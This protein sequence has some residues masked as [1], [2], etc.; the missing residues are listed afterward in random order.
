MDLTG[1][2]GFY[3]YSSTAA[4]FF[5]LTLLLL[6]SRLGSKTSQTQR[7]PPSFFWVALL[8]TAL[9]A[10]ATASGYSA[11][12]YIPLAVF[13][14][15][16]FKSLSWL[17]FLLRFSSD[18]MPE[19]RSWF[20]VFA[21][22]W[23][24]QLS[25][26]I[27]II[28]CMTI[29]LVLRASGNESTFIQELPT[30]TLLITT[31]TNLIVIE[32]I[33]RNSDRVRRW[34]VKH[35]CLGLGI[36][37]CFDLYLFSNTLLFR[38]LDG[39]LINFRSLVYLLAI[40]LLGISLLRLPSWSR[41][42]QIS[43]E[44]VFHTATLTG[45]GVYL[46]VMA[47]AGYLISVYGGTW[48]QLLQ[49][50]F[51]AGAL[52]LLLIL[53]FSDKIRSSIKVILNKHFF[54]YKYDYREE[55]LRTNSLLSDLQMEIPERICTLFA[56]MIKSP[57]CSLW[58]RTNNNSFKKL[59]HTH[60]PET[61]DIKEASGL[62][63]FLEQTQWIIDLGEYENFPE[64]YEHLTLPKHLTETPQA[65]LILPLIFNNDLIGIVLVKRS[66]FMTVVNWEDRDLLKT[67]SKQA[68]SI[69]AQHL[70]N[71][72][73]I[74]ARQFEAFNRL[75]AYVV[76]DLKNILAQQSLIVTNAERHKHKPAFVDDVIKT[77]DNSVKRMTK[78]MQQMREGMRG[79]QLDILNV[80][81]IVVSTIE[82]FEHLNPPLSLELAPEALTTKAD[83]EQ[84]ATVIGHLL[85]NA[86]DATDSNGRITVTTSKTLDEL[87]ID[88]EDTGIGM[89]EAFIQERLF[90]AF[91][92]TKGL[93]GMGIGA[94]ESRETI[95][96]WGG[97]ISVT[98][99]E[100]KGSKF[101]I[102]LPFTPPE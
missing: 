22:S 71:Q 58:S 9:W 32:Q 54:S 29:P 21:R 43:R 20:G 27:G 87:R 86:F 56:T 62:I 26:S 98:S 76:H 90:K 15:E 33:Y 77:V 25:A 38:Q 100:G 57:G 16:T 28:L 67:A 65:W 96:A 69:L 74:E 68:A 41:K 89:S 2:I 45:A 8:S 10:G 30:I 42:L 44:V 46:I 39:D 18:Q 17:V 37:F 75:S 12:T 36:I 47:F 85:Q 52:T 31:V 63:S 97:D 49:F 102:S 80:N 19:Q 35:L 1:H 79:E 40:P 83:F 7:K 48:G 4:G 95:R 59:A 64:R 73:L 66:S 88:I 94:Y 23:K 14:T 50:T 99:T 53:L 78:L 92:S 34:A 5:L 93:T 55:W 61:W 82:R 91:D 51:L 13:A 72:A 81:D 3:I 24:A 84:L 60:M 6:L 101:T 70:A 11:A